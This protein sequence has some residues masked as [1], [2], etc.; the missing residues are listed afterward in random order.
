M[1]L[2]PLLQ[3]V[4]AFLRND[5]PRDPWFNA[6]SGLVRYEPDLFDPTPDPWRTRVYW[7][8]YRSVRIVRSAPRNTYY[9]IKYFIQ[10]GRRGWAD[11]DT[12]SLDSYLDGFMP[13]ALRYLKAHKHGVP[14]GMFEGL[15]VN[16][17]G[18]HDDAEF[19]IAEAR[20]D[21]VMDQ[22]VAGF[23]ASTRMQDGLYEKE[24]GSYPLDRPAGVSR[25]AWATVKDNRFAASQLLQA[26]D[27]KVFEEGMGLFLTHYRSLW[28]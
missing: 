27:Q 17:R 15:P 9:A 12:W 22:M 13:H 16:D 25:D 1:F 8:I 5:V 14:G 4:H 3:K 11:C 23:E 19:K 28:D 2:K 24:L 10:R 21:A 6:G 20:W 18:Y 26:R 7:A